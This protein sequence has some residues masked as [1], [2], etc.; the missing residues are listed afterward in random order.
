M[1]RSNPVRKKHTSTADLL[2][3]LETPQ[4]IDTPV[5][6]SA[7]RHSYKPVGGISPALFGG[8]MTEEEVESVNKRRP[9]SGPKLREMTGSGIFAA[10]TESDS[11][12]SGSSE[13]NPGNK[14]GVRIYQQ[15]LGGISQISF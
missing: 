11:L 8:Q 9:C 3:W 10:R 14:T 6:G 2:T 7:S 4:P 13:T 12:E 1:E 5:Q 15:A